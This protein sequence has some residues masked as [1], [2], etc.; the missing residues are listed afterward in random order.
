MPQPPVALVVGGQSY[1]VHSDAPPDTLHRLAQI[2][3]DRVR[4]CNAAGHLSPTQALLYA[5]LILAEDLLNERDLRQ[6]VEANARSS[7]HEILRRVDA[8]LHNTADL[9]NATAST[10]SPQAPV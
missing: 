8:A 5:A 7:L 2:V 1:R 4:S 9:L 6:S 10:S 3:D